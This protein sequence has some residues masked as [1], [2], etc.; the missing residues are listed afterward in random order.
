MVS[1]GVVLLQSSNLPC[2][3]EERQGIDEKRKGRRC[4][5]E[6]SGFLSPVSKLS[7]VWMLGGLQFRSARRRHLLITCLSTTI[8]P[9]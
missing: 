3:V 5:M 4:Y 2:Y 1:F 6:D 8:V 9:R 7:V